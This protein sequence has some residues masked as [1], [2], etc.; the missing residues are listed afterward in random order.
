LTSLCESSSC[1]AEQ[2]GE[3]DAQDE[4]NTPQTPAVESGDGGW[5][6]A[7]GEATVTPAAPEEEEEVTKSYDEYLAERAAA[8]IQGLGKK[9]GRQV[10]TESVEGTQF[11]REAIDEFF[12]GKVREYVHLLRR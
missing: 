12:N 9:E 1:T 7:E 2:Q 5:G 8:Q 11:R 10:N 6:A 3:K 4:E